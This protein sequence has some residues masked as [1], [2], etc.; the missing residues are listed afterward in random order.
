MGPA[1]ALNTLKAAGDKKDEVVS[2]VSK[3]PPPGKGSPL[4]FYISSQKNFEI[5]RAHV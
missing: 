1:Q 5:G 3:M 2:D 4:A